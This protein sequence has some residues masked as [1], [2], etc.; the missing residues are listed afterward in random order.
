MFFFFLCVFAPK[1]VPFEAKI[2]T[3]KHVNIFG[4]IFTPQSVYFQRKTK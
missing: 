3:L 4:K 1:E 2:G